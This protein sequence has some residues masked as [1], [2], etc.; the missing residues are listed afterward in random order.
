M[1]PPIH[2]MKAE[3]PALS[4]SDTTTRNATASTS[5]TDISRAR[6]NAV[7]ADSSSGWGLKM[8]SKAFFIS[9]NTAEAPISAVP[10]PMRVLNTPC[11]SFLSV[12]ARMSWML[13]AASAPTSPLIWPM[14]WPRAASSPNTAPAIASRISMSGAMAKMV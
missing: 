4:T 3:V 13:L 5:A 11:E 14:I 2:W 10:M 8:V 1:R 9:T 7:T 6:T 12:A